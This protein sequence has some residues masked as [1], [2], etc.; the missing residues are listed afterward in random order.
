M[1]V[2]GTE[3]YKFKGKDSEIAATPLCLGKI[4]KDWS[5]DNMK[6]KTGFNGY[7]YDF[8]VDYDAADVDDIV[9]IHK[10]LTKK[11]T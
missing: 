7:V 6:K 11:I 10:Y 4:S 2:N 5:T 8:S 1:F 9:D 3:I